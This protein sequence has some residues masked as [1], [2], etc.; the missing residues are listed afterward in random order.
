MYYGYY[1]ERGFK[2]TAPN[3]YYNLGMDSYQVVK[4][5]YRGVEKV[6]DE[7][8]QANL[9]QIKKSLEGLGFNVN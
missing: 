1:L 7:A 5:V 4:Y 9:S 8:T 2:D 3:D 6:E